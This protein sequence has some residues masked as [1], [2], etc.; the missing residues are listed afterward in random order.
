M[1]HARAW[2][3]E[4]ELFQKKLTMC[5]ARQL[6]GTTQPCLALDILPGKVLRWLGEDEEASGKRRHCE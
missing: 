5:G 4:V 2:G 3:R 6:R 1:T